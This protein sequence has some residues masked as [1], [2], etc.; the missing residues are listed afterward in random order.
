VETACSH[1]VVQRQK[2]LNGMVLY[3]VPSFGDV[4]ARSNTCPMSISSS[5]YHGRGSR[6]VCKKFIIDQE[7]Q[8]L[9]RLYL[10]KTLQ[11][12]RRSM[13]SSYSTSEKFKG[14]VLVHK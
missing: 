10:V 1:I 6:R 12:A 4:L 7:L 14:K 5:M 8:Q 3:I 9:W 2:R 11:G 13:Y